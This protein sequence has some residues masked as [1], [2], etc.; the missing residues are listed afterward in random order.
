MSESAPG[1]SNNNS[2]ETEQCHE[3]LDPLREQMESVPRKRYHRVE[4]AYGSFARSFTVPDD[5]D[6]AKVHAEF[7][8]GILNVRIEKAERAKP[9]TIDVKVS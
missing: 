2:L 1:F 4:R 3:Q 7:K 6:P 5:A 8:D 9:K